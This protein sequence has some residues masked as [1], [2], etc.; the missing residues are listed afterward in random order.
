[1][2]AFEVVPQLTYDRLPCRLFGWHRDKKVEIPDAG[3]K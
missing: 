2:R 3:N 1:V